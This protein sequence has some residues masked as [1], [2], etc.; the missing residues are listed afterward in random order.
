MKIIDFSGINVYPVRYWFENN[1]CIIRS[2]M[3]ENIDS[4]QDVLLSMKTQLILGDSIYVSFKFGHN[5][6]NKDETEIWVDVEIEGVFKVVKIIP[7]YESNSIE[8]GVR[9]VGYE[10]IT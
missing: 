2:L 7:R 3:I 1:N 8:L 10:H 6:A 5:I 9:K 4:Q